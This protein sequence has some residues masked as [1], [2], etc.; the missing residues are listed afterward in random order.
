M[1]TREENIKAI[2]ETCFAGFKEKLIDEAVK[3][4]LKL[5]LH[6]GAEKVSVHDKDHIWYKG[7]QYISLSRFLQ[8]VKAE[9]MKEQRKELHLFCEKCCIEE[10]EATVKQRYCRYCGAA[11]KVDDIVN[12]IEEAKAEGVDCERNI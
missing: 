6:N 4:I 10:K 3:S 11:Y 9:N 2:L 12:M 7:R 5:E 8:A 1:L